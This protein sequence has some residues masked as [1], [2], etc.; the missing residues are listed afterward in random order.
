MDPSSQPSRLSRRRRILFAFITVSLTVISVFLVSEILMR[1][2]GFRPWAPLPLFIAKDP[3]GPYFQAHPTRGFSHV[4][5]RSRLT[6]V[7]DYTFRVTHRDDGLRITQPL[8]T[9]SLVPR[10]QIWIFGCSFTHG[11]SVSDEG[12]Y[13]WI[14]QSKLPDYEVVNFGTDGYGDV[15]S[16]I[17]FR[18]T[19]KDGRKPAV[20]VVAYA[21]FHDLR[22]AMTRTWR[23]NLLGDS[24]I[25]P[26]NC[27]Y[28]KLSPDG[29]LVIVSEVVR[30]PGE[31]LLRHS[32]LLNYL[33]ERLNSYLN[34]KY[35]EP[36]RGSSTSTTHEVSKAVL[37]EFWDECKANGIPFILAGISDDPRT[38]EMLD[39]F[40]SKGAPTVDISVDRRII[41]N[42]NFPFDWHPSVRANRQTAQKL[43]DFL[44]A[45]FV[46]HADPAKPL[47]STPA[48]R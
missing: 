26:I 43:A 13:P 4:P 40:K 9:P 46:D 19:L 14:L 27:P 16:L 45:G 17:Q 24:R 2:Y 5:G 15:Q 29:K 8:T 25:G 33:D 7:G 30:Y 22:N 42:T 47:D 3:P 12:T 35:D 11:F 18:E 48:P 10:K 23:K 28:G 20:V 36:P 34:E 39:Y 1:W 32:A 21:H 41:E 38:A 37:L 31:F 44:T 6:L